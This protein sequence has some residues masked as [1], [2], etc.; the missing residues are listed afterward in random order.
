MKIQELLRT[1]EKQGCRIERCKNNHWQIYPPTGGIIVAS[2]TPSDHRSIR[3][4]VV[5][6]RRAGVVVGPR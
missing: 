5:R 1:A 3:D 6:L 2:A 4:V